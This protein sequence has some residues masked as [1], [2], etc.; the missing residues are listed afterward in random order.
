MLRARVEERV[1]D[2]LLQV[3]KEPRALVAFGSFVGGLDRAKVVK[4]GSPRAPRVVAVTHIWDGLGGESEEEPDV[5]ASTVRLARGGRRMDTTPLDAAFETREEAVDVANVVEDVEANV[6]KLAAD[7][8][9][10]MPAV[11]TEGGSAASRAGAATEKATFKLPTVPRRVAAGGVAVGF[12]EGENLPPKG[13]RSVAAGG[14]LSA[15]VSAALEAPAARRRCENGKGTPYWN[16]TFN[17]PGRV[18]PGLRL[19]WFVHL[20]HSHST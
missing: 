3:T 7:V 10:K 1:A 12:L 19:S 9:T 4:M 13:K 2:L 8:R 18:A 17:S 11:G 16:N 15:S 14:F 5:G 6:A 20:Q